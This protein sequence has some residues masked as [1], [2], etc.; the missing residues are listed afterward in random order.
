MKLFAPKCLENLQDEKIQNQFLKLGQI[1][2]YTSKVIFNSSL[3]VIFVITTGMWNA[4]QF[5]PI[6]HSCNQKWFVHK[7]V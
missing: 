6:V 1:S 5:Q 7:A 3:I 2:Y 4:M